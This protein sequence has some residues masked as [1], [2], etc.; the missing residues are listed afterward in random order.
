MEDERP[1]ITT[2]QLTRYFAGEASAQEAAA[3]K[4]W[5]EASPENQDTLFELQLVW[6]DTGLVRFE[7][8]APAKTYDV[9]AAW[10]NVKARKRAAEPQ[11]ETTPET[12]TRAFDWVWKVAASVAL[13]VALGFLART[14]FFAPESITYTAMQPTAHLQLADGSSVTL[15][16]SSSLSYPEEFSDDSRE[17]TLEGK[18]FFEVEPD[19]ARPFTIHAGP[20][21]V[22]VLGTSFTVDMGA[23][24]ISVAVE[25]GQ[26][27]FS[28]GDQSLVLEA[29]QGGVFSLSTNAFQQQDLSSATGAD[30]FWRTQTLRFTGQRLPDVVAALEQAYGQTIQLQG[31]DLANC[32][33]NVTFQNDSLENVLAVIALTLDL[34]VTQTDA[35]FTLTGEGCSAD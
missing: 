9:E 31:D 2:E 11:V 13:I 25:T 30:Q 14:Y 8:A 34:E 28:H 29:N 15:S 5:A 22:Q 4:S 16:E 33:L 17:V 10:Q 23:S 35:G 27:R 21:D 32:S 19:P 6:L 20:T 1:E 26:V 3:V 7:P 12:R 24:Q 18:A